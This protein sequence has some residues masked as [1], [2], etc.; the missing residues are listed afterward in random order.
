MKFFIKPT[1]AST[2]NSHSKRNCLSFWSLGIASLAL[3]FLYSCIQNVPGSTDVAQSEKTSAISD[4]ESGEMLKGMKGA[5]SS[6]EA[7]AESLDEDDVAEAGHVSR[8]RVPHLIQ[9]LK[10]ADVAAPMG[11][12]DHVVAAKSIQGEHVGHRGH[13]A[14]ISDG[15]QL[16]VQRYSHEGAVRPPTQTRRHLG[17]RRHRLQIAGQVD[18]LDI[19]GQDV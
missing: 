5:N 10:T 16:A 4:K 17:Y 14:I 13:R 15:V 6:E 18:G 7:V 1:D 3:F 12:D 8:T 19:L 2:V 9:F 11:V